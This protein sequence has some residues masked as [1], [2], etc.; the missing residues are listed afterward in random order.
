MKKKIFFSTNELDES[1]VYLDTSFDGKLEFKFIVDDNL[2]IEDTINDFFDSG[3]FD[4]SLSG[5]YV[6]KDEFNYDQEL[7]DKLDNM[8][9]DGSLVKQEI[10]LEKT[11]YFDMDLD[12]VVEILNKNKMLLNK[13]IVLCNINEYD[14]KL[15][16]ELRS[17]FGDKINV[18]RFIINGNTEIISFDDLVKTQEYIDNIANHINSLSFSPIEKV[19]YAFD[20]VRDRKY[21]A[22]DEDEYY[23]SRDLTTSLFGNDIVCVG[24]SAFLNALLNKIGINNEPYMLVNNDG[25]GHQTN[26]AY[27]KDDKYGIDGVYFFDSTWDCKK[28]DSNNHYYLYR[29]FGKT[30]EE[31]DKMGYD[32]FDVS[33]LHDFDM[34]HANKFVSSL[35]KN[36]FKKLDKKFATLMN[37][38]CFLINGE[39]IFTYYAFNKEMLDK[40]DAPEEMFKKVSENDAICKTIDCIDK[41]NKPISGNT[42]LK[43]LYNVRKVQLSEYQ[44]KYPYGTLDFA[45]TLFASKKTIDGY[46][47]DADKMYYDIYKS[48]SKDKPIRDYWEYAKDNEEMSKDMDYTK[49][50]RVLKK[51]VDNNKD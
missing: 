42:F 39:K 41:M 10:L 7:I 19:M 45:R 2:M 49:L 24:F 18:L 33:S 51:Y 16:D 37:K 29:F 15:I 31:I 21:Q 5:I 48:Y 46:I 35:N 17:K 40:L 9:N 14:D 23:K 4:I 44:D 34:K 32:K 27:I 25:N 3:E 26:I 1:N 36:G 13:K 47:S 50:A 6:S 12:D 22:N 38:I 8:C 43:I 11:Y 20:I 30:K 28:D